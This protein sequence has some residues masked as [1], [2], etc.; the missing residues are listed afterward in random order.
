MHLTESL[1]AAFEA[2]ADSTYLR[3]AERITE[4]IVR[5]RAA[6]NA[7]RLP[8]HFTQDWRVDR[9]YSGSLVFR[10]HGTTPGH[11]LEWTRLLLQLWE[12]GECKLDWLRA[13]AK[14]LLRRDGIRT[15]ADST[16][17]WIGR[18][19]R[20]YATATGGHVAK[21]WGRRLS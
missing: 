15:R 21:A 13:C 19:D 18:A 10:P 1:M 12:L 3:M 2:T 11:W 16:T 14:S 9:D 4:L 20:S 5:E 17:R 7:W 6:E 8:E